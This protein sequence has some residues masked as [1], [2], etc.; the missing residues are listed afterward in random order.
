MRPIFIVERRHV[1]RLE[2]HRGA[3]IRR[4]QREFFDLQIR[5]AA[6]VECGDIVRIELQGACVA[7]DR[8][9][10]VVAQAVGVAHVGQRHRLLVGREPR[11]V[12]DLGA[13]LDRAMH[14]GRLRAVV[15]MRGSGRRGGCDHGASKNGFKEHGGLPNQ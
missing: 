4:R 9:V 14:V 13:S 3:E 7:R 5:R 11:H 1:A 12:Q 10:R 8:G 6:I 15:E 2:R